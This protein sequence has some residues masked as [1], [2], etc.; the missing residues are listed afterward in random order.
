MELPLSA[1][2]VFL[3]IQILGGR[4]DELAGSYDSS[5]GLLLAPEEVEEMDQIEE[6]L[7]DLRKDGWTP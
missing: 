1:E 7:S 5:E 4:H 6:I 3:I 2:D